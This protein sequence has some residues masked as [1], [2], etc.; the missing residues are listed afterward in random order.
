MRKEIERLEEIT[1]KKITRNRFHFLRFNIPASYLRLVKL[2]IEEDYSL[3]HASRAGFRAGTCSPF[4]FFNLVKNERTN[5]RIHPFAFMDAT[6]THYN[7]L[8]SSKA[9]DKILQIMQYVKEVEGPFLGLWHN[10]S[11]TEQREWKGWRNIF[12]TVAAEASALMKTP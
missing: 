4:Y 1:A 11:F 5:F 10:S 6:L 7:R 9:L 3:G 12:E 2:G 8:S